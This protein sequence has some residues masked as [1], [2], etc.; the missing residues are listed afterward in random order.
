MGFHLGKMELQINHKL[1]DP[2]VEIDGRCWTSP[3]L[4]WAK[5]ES[6]SVNKKAT[7]GKDRK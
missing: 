1:W 7:K 4:S 2:N 6:E 3:N 5:Y